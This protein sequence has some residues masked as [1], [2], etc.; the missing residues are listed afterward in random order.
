MAHLNEGICV[1][2]VCMYVYIFVLH[3]SLVDTHNVTYFIH[4]IMKFDVIFTSKLLNK[5]AFSSSKEKYILLGGYSVI[6]ITQ[7]NSLQIQVLNIHVYK[8]PK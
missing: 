7:I 1:Y 3:H 2:C 6:I 4:C 8:L 5:N